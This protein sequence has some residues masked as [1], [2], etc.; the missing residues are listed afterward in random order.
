MNTTKRKVLSGLIWKFGERISAQAVSFAVSVVLARMLPTEAYGLIALVMIFI[1]FANCIVVNG[2]G[3][4]LIQK[5]DADNLDFSS[6]LYFQI[7]LS[8]ILY[9]I[10]FF[11]AP[12]AA[13]RHQSGR[14]NVPHAVLG[15]QLKSMLRSLLPLEKHA[16][17][18]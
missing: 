13:M 3:S 16:A 12:F 8:L 15:I 9:V 1:T 17:P 11:T 18:Q 4:S 6:V 14:E 10:L 5:K 7:A 2:F